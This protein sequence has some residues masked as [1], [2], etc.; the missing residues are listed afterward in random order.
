[1][2]AWITFIPL[3][4]AATIFLISCENRRAIET[5]GMFFSG[6]TLF[7]SL[8]LLIGFDVN[9]P[10][11]QLQINRLWIPNLGINFRMGIDGISLWM[12]LL[13][14]FLTPIAVYF[15]AGSIKKDLREFLALLLFLETGM[16]GVFVSLDLVLFYIFWEVMLI[17]MYFLI[18]VWGAER[19]IYSAVKFFLFTMFGSV[20]MLIAILVLYREAGIQSFDIEVLKTAAQS[21]TPRMAVVLFW[22]FFLAFAIKVPVFP[23]HTWLPDAHTDAP[24]AGSVILA[25]VLLKMGTY[26][27]LRFSLPMFPHQCYDFA[28]LI[29][30]LAVI[31]I[32]YAAWVATM[33]PDMKRLIAYS[34]VSHLGFSVLGIFSFTLEGMTGGLLHMVNHGL[35]T[36]ALFLIVGML[37]DRTH[38]KLI[39]RF[40]G[41]TRIMP[42]F[43]VCFLLVMLSS[44]GLPGLNGFVGEFLVLVGSAKAAHE[45]TFPGASYILTVCAATGVIWGAVYMLWM[46]QRV[47]LGPVKHKENENLQDLNKREKWCLIPIIVLCVVIG[48]F[49]K[50]LIKPMEAPL[51]ELVRI[52]QQANQPVSRVDQ[53]TGLEHQMH[54]F[55]TQ[56]GDQ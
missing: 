38:T 10:G 1:M 49:P 35:S 51:K 14:A 56:R 2:L 39:E 9:N 6:L 43:S 34:S 3:I 54:E 4:G 21:L 22:F 12:V 40:G 25:G 41:I 18:G 20:L 5:W 7:L 24:T 42:F 30:S 50:L 13:T 8:L 44:I 15:S 26:G 48:I 23:F 28:L 37:Y 11:M 16:I 32:I 29:S 55:G 17:P 53:I 46:F 47:M 27:F 45:L 36:G 19:R 31:G 52:V 33:Q